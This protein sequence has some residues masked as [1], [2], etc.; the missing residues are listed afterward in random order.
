MQQDAERASI[1][2]DVSQQTRGGNPNTTI[3]TDAAVDSSL[4][5]CS[6]LLL[7]MNIGE[8][9]LGIDGPSTMRWDT[10]T[11]RSFTDRHF[12]PPGV[13]QLQ[14]D[15]PQIGRLFT[16][17]N[18]KKIGGFRIAWTVNLA[19]HLRL[20]EDPSSSSG[21]VALFSCVSFLRFQHRCVPPQNQLFP[22]SPITE[23]LR[24]LAL[25]LPQNDAAT[26]AWLRSQ[27]LDPLLTECGSLATHERRFEAFAHWHN[28]LVVLKQALDEARPRTL[29]QWWFDRRNGVQWYTFWVAILVFLVTIFFGLVQ[30]VEGG[31]QVSSLESSIPPFRISKSHKLR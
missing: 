9:P 24:T 8:P 15:K 18:L 27:E 13:H 11:L 20:I 1:H 28:R 30:S 2:Q 6:R 29:A 23:T 25:L 19:D 31:L 22:T 14:P 26:Q 16:A 3:T 17:V 12:R 7:M 21:V 4:N 10:G 5:L